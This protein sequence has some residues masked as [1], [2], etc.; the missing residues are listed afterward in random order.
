[1]ALLF[2]CFEVSQQFPFQLYWVL[3]A[4]FTFQLLHPLCVALHTLPN[5][6]FNLFV[7]GVYIL[8]VIGSDLKLARLL[9]G[10][11]DRTRGFLLEQKLH[12]LV[13]QAFHPRIVVVLLRGGVL[14]LIRGLALNSQDLFALEH[15]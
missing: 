11:A 15:D 3:Y 14:R 6:P 12:L 13:L 9:V 8:L 1:L 5:V 10:L 2:I 4:F 7:V